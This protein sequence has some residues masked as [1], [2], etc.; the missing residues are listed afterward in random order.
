ML[1]KGGGGEE[2]SRARVVRIVEGGMEE[3]GRSKKRGERRCG[4]VNSVT[5]RLT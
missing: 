2:G 4:E 3:G 1:K 5:W